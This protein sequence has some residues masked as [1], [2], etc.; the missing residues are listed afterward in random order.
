MARVRDRATFEAL[1]RA[2]R[3][4]Q[5]PVSLCR[6]PPDGS[7]APRVAYAVGKRAGNAVV[8]NRIRRRLR[9]AVAGEA[10][11]FSP[12]AAYLVGGTREV[13][14]MSFDELCA[15]VAALAAE[16]GTAR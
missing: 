10:D 13:I 1:G 16:A 2:R 5:G 4:R 6:V 7:G 9:A 15:T 14:S 8:R 3:H 12:G 11:A